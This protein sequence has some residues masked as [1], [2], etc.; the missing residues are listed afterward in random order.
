MSRPHS[1]TFVRR[2]DACSQARCTPPSWATESSPY[3]T[4]TRR[5]RSSARRTPTSPSSGGRSACSANSSRNMRRSDFGDLEYRAN[6]APFVTSG[7]LTRVNTGSSRFVKYGRRTSRS[8]SLNSSE[9]NQRLT[10]A[11]VPPASDTSGSR[12]GQRDRRRR[13]GFR[14]LRFDDLHGRSALDLA[15]GPRVLPGDGALG[16][17]IGWL[18][19]HQ[20]EV[21]PRVVDLALRLVD[22]L[23][24]HVRDPDGP[25]AAGDDQVH[26]AVLG[27]P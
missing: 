7:R 17:L 2:F 8:S 21:Q 25:R 22:V 20:R 10:P 24:D 13:C 18:R 5:Y 12:C 16:A 15:L 26:L 11:I 27:H 19:A 3:S 23:A 9:A 1:S 4:N 6:R 14:A